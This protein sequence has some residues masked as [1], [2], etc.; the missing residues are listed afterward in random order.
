MADA[1]IFDAVRTPRGK[2]R[3]ARGDRLGGALCAISPQ[4]LVAGLIGALE[5]R[6]PGMSSSV[7]RLILGCVGQVGVQ[8][9][10]IALVS[11]LASN[12]PDTVAVKT[13]NNY[14]V[15]GLSAVTDAAL[16]AQSEAGGLSLAGGVECLSQVKF[17]A[18]KAAYYSDPDV[19]RDL[20]YAPP[21]MGAELMASL[22]GYA[23][24]DLDRVSLMSHK[25]AAKAWADGRYASSVIPVKDE[26]GQTILDQD[27]LIRGD[28]ELDDIASMPP[29]FAAQG[30]AGFDD[31]MLREYPA[32]DEI[33][34]VHSVAN[35]PGMADGAS[36]VLVGNRAAGE[37]A[38]LVP[39]ARITAF[40]EISDDPVLQFTA[41]FSAM[42]LVLK[43]AG[44]SLAD[45][46]RIEFME[47]FA[48]V[49]LK[50]QRDYDV[51]WDKVNVNGGHLAMGHPMGATGGILVTALTH[52][53][54]RCGGQF[55]LVVAHAGS[56]IGMAMVIER[57]CA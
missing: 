45:M 35:C 2:G 51:D 20:R 18:D 54:E 48:A 10:H 44:L 17:L 56:G 14:C 43:Q 39:R 30:A 7:K 8:G 19:M 42:E 40:A 5:E 16:W 52:E 33:S 49:P 46:D 50:F 23:K 53:L 21:V 47:A 27:E 4:S 34:H 24:D 28:M 37:R 22:E 11:R 13:V 31:M 36:L 1:Y 38:G 26:K 57:V 3:P 25:R 29:A 6:C 32:L 12:L 55:G 15:S 41:G 9:G